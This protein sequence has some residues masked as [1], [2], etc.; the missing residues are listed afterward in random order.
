V[1]A[2]AVHE[3]LASTGYTQGYVDELKRYYKQEREEYEERLR[4]LER[5]HIS[6]RES[7][8]SEIG[9]LKQQ[10]EDSYREHKGQMQA[11]A[12]ANTSK[13]KTLLQEK[14]VLIAELQLKVRLLNYIVDCRAEGIAQTRNG[15]AEPNSR[16]ATALKST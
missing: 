10:I 7:L 3:R 13:L 5:A 16:R 9:L 1:T 6:A 4:S 8:E 2:A 14:D 15:P 11:A 12:N